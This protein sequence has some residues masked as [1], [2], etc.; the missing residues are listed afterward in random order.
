VSRTV[1]VVPCYNEAHRLRRD[2]FLRFAH[3]NPS[4]GLLLVN[5]GS[6]DE[7][8]EVLR[9]IAS[10]S[11]QNVEVLDQQP[12]RG[13][14]ETV[15]AGML[16]AFAKGPRFA[17]YWDA[18]L[19]TPF[20]EVPRFVEILETNPKVELVFG[21]RV[22]LMG[23][24]IERHLQR[25]LRGRVFA[26]VVS[27]ALGL[28]IY[29]TQCGAKLFRANADVAALFEEPWLSRWIFDVE[30][31]ARLIRDR[32]AGGKAP[33]EEVL[34]ELP[35]RSWRDVEGSKLRSRDFFDA[36]FDL[37]AIYRRYLA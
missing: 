31:V 12:N 18:D 17:G 16:E 21:S 8:L 20:E 19:A 3:A 30:L 34:R 27:L 24:Q 13:K 23:H 4:I 7:T 25:L 15:R 14:A 35:L 11:P 37:A 28:S 22:K 5:D 10:E 33:V 6:S 32:K 1:V 2:A 36:I 9:K 29:D 26:T